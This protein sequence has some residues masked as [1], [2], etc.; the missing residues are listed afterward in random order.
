MFSSNYP[1][2]KLLIPYILGVFLAY[3]TDFGN[4]PFYFCFPVLLVFLLL[5]TIFC[6]I[7]RAKISAWGCILLTIIPI[8]LGFSITNFH[9]S[10]PF[11]PEE[12][13]FIF[14]HKNWCVTIVE[15]P[16]EKKRSY[17]LIV[18]IEK[19]FEGKNIE[20]KALL[21]I[22][23]DSLSKELHYGDR[24]FIA[25]SFSWVEKQR[26][27]E[28]FDQQKYL[29]RKGIYL[30]GYVSSEGWRKIETAPVNPIK[31]TALKIQQML[32]AHFATSGLAGDEYDIITAI[33]LGADE[34]M[35]A[36]LK[37]QYASAGVSHILSVSGM[38]VGIMFMLVNFIL[39]PLSYSRKTKFL[40]A[41]IIL[42][43]IWFYAAV[44]GL[45]PSVQRA[46]V[47]FSF[48]TCGTL[49]E[50]NTNI[51][52]SLF[53][54]LFILLLVSP[55]L[56]FEIGF[57]LSYLAVFGIVLFQ[58]PIFK[59]MKVKTFFG[60]YL[61]ELASVSIAAQ[62]ATFPI[63]VYYF[64]QFPN[65]FLIS[66]LSVIFLSSL[67]MITG[68]LTLF[69]SFWPLIS[70]AVGWILTYEI[71]LMNWIVKVVESLPG[72][73]TEGLH[74]SIS[75]AF[76]LYCIIGFLFYFA[77]KK[78][79]KYF[80]AGLTCFTLFTIE[81][82]FRKII[83]VQ[84]Q[85]ITIYAIPKATALHFNAGT[86]GWLLSDSVSNK[87]NHYYKFYI[88][89]HERNKQIN[90]KIIHRDSASITTN[91]FFKHNNFISFNGKTIYLLNR[92]E[93]LYAGKQSMDIDFL[94]IQNNP[95]TSPQVIK[96]LFRPKKVII[97][98]NNSSFHEKKW[99]EW[100]E[101]Q[102]LDY[103]SIP[104]QGSIILKLIP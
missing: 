99:R 48:A 18:C 91:I 97:D 101:E 100:C 22:Q 34:T 71:K 24:L 54:S 87:Q 53:A 77:L 41:V 12:E 26:N 9:F 61:W 5:A 52:H 20:K 83:N 33:L 32:S 2:L 40:K 13:E 88:Q 49:L 4:I 37:S 92:N 47:M 70:G 66:N 72:A 85:E 78:K 38:H 42:L 21:Y 14:N 39:K 82:A 74:Y 10:K 50:R 29:R 36:E 81:F 25:T 60:R 80:I 103:H 15:E 68:I 46:A 45:S 3:F 28:A 35:D 23:K 31:K 75:Q 98:G 17:K 79:N 44:T 43:F 67:I 62:L 7:S 16:I 95:Y 27:P 56:I 30:T 84:R 76:L 1:I 96:T 94:I 11:S 64:G 55:L 65:Y 86:K 102:K 19:S 51:F 63:S 6:R 89:N 90:S 8:L 57:Q 69:F 93:R 59:L 73:V 58:K 104:E